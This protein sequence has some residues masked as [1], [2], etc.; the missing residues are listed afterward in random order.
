M[1]S[2]SQRLQKIVLGLPKFI[3][4]KSGNPNF[5]RYLVIYN[6]TLE[7]IYVLFSLTMAVLLYKWEFTN[8]EVEFLKVSEKIW[9]PGL[10]D[11]KARKPWDFLILT[12]SAST[13]SW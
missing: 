2:G 9:T 1:K 13:V 8:T 6:K 4:R 3:A 10:P 7:W 11:I 12:V 5:E